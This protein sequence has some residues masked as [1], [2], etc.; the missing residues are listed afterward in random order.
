MALC[1]C[2]RRTALIK[3]ALRPQPE[4]WT[5]VQEMVDDSVWLDR[6]HGHAFSARLERALQRI[7]A[8]EQRRWFFSWK[9]LSRQTRRLKAAAAFWAQRHPQAVSTPPL[10][11]WRQWAARRQAKKALEHARVA[12]VVRRLQA[13]CLRGAMGAWKDAVRDSAGDVVHKLREELQRAKQQVE[14][15]NQT[16]QAYDA[17]G[18]ERATGVPQSSGQSRE[19]SPSRSVRSATPTNDMGH[20]TA[21]VQSTYNLTDFVALMAS[22]YEDVPRHLNRA[23]TAASRMYG[24]GERCDVMWC[25]GGCCRM[26][27]RNLRRRS[28]QALSGW[29]DRTRLAM[30]AAAMLARKRKGLVSQCVRVWRQVRA[31]AF[32]KTRGLTGRPFPYS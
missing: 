16:V 3:L 6:V 27:Q 13:L 4:Q 29:R 2:C 10:E 28:R 22:R 21:V 31:I 19:P 17:T 32:A 26:R 8:C 5:P 1:N 12:R 11:V 14:L 18:I 23:H 9:A 25:D 15:L 7:A 24:R 30:G 20:S